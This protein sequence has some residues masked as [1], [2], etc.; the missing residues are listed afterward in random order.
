MTRWWEQVNLTETPGAIG[1]AKYT[2]IHLV[3]D[4]F[5]KHE[6]P[7]VILK[8]G[9][10]NKVIHEPDDIW[11]KSK[12]YMSDF[13][14]YKWTCLTT[15]KRPN[16]IVEIH[17]KCEEFIKE[18]SEKMINCFLMFTHKNI[19]QAILETDTLTDLWNEFYEWFMK[20]KRDY[21]AKM[22][23]EI[24]KNTKGKITEIKPVRS[25]GGVANLLKVLT[26]TM[27]AQGADIRSIAKVQYKVCIDAGIYLPDEFITDVATVLDMEETAKRDFE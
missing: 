15:G 24:Q 1:A 17:T 20:R 11:L 25:H 4:V 10:R 3:E 27:Q 16:T 19:E 8:N 18:H 7:I 13:Q 22:E 5:E 21:M 6:P 23:I 26:K 14:W 9:I 12:D 2:F